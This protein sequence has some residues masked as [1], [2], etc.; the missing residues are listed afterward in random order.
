MSCDC[1]CSVVI[2][3]GAV[4]W[5]EVFDLVSSDDT[6]LLFHKYKVECFSKATECNICI[7][8]MTCLQ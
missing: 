6:H 5:S 8:I 1:L 2:P 7:L 4:G 3:H